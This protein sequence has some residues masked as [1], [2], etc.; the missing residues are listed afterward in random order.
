MKDFLS[1]PND[2][3]ETEP[4]ELG[5]AFVEVMTITLSKHLAEQSKKSWT[6]ELENKLQQAISQ[7]V[8]QATLHGLSTI[9]VI[10]T[11]PSGQRAWRNLDIAL[12]SKERRLQ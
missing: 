4:P 1:D 6:Q 11:K 5:P 10:V 7:L 9:K 2:R 12:I 3:I 8:A